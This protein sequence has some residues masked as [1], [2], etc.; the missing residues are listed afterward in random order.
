MTSVVAAGYD[1]HV[2][3]CNL[4]CRQGMNKQNPMF[5][6]PYDNWAGVDTSGVESV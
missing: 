3:W 5:V 2:T 4:Q 6:H 1:A